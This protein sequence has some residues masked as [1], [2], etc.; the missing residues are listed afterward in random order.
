MFHIVIFTFALLFLLFPVFPK[1]EF[2]T[3]TPIVSGWVEVFSGDGKTSIISAY[4]YLPR[5]ILRLSV[6]GKL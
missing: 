3:A 4:R 1:K 2:A 5:Q 6:G